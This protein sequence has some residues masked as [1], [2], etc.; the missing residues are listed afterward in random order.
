MDVGER[1]LSS[2]GALASSACR[3][4]GQGA[5]HPR[6]LLDQRALRDGDV[7]FGSPAVEL[8][9]ALENA[10]SS[11]SGREVGTG[12]VVNRRPAP[13]RCRHDR[14]DTRHQQRYAFR[15]GMSGSPRR[16]RYTSGIRSWYFS[17]T[18]TQSIPAPRAVAAPLT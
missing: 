14:H 13:S 3:I 8:D 4:S 11:A 5:F 18:P 6:M 10:V 15:V 17:L 1:R 9:Y 7:R 12:C 16:R 2:L